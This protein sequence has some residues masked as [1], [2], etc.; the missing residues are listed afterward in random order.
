MHPEL[1]ELKALVAGRLDAHRRREIDDHLGTCA[2]C[3][4]HYVALMLGSASPKTAEAE[5]RQGRVPSSTGLLSFAAAGG[6]SDAPAYGIDAPLAAQPSRPPV[7]RPPHS[8]LA[9]L[10]TERRQLQLDGASFDGVGVFDADGPSGI[11]VV[12]IGL[13]RK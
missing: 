7:T 1:F 10:E 11:G 8:N 2:D 5:A 3:S 13:G 6:V 4:R 12:K 9:A